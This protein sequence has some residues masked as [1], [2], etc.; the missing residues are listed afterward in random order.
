MAVYRAGMWLYASN[1]VAQLGGYLFWFVAAAT[2]KADVLG[3]VAYLVAVASILAFVLGLGVP[4]A[5]AR[6]YPATRDSTYVSGSLALSLIGAAAAALTALWR[7]SLALLTVVGTLSTYYGAYFQSRLDTFPIF[8]ATLAGQAARVALVPLLAHYGPDALATTY[9]IPGAILTVLGAAASRASP[10]L[11]KI[12]ELVKA[13][14]AVWL[15]G[16][17]SVLGTN[18]G[19][20]AAYNLANPET[21]GYVYIA[22]VLAN[23]AVGPATIITGVLLPYLSSTERREA[24]AENA[25]RLSLVVSL[26][27]AAVL[28]FGGRHFLELLGAHYVQA[29]PALVIYTVA[30]IL[31]LPASVLSSLTYAQGAYTT[32]LAGGLATNVTR[33]I[34]YLLYGASA[35][36]AAASF[37]AG[38]IVALAYYAAMQRRVAMSISRISPKIAVTAVPAAM[39][40][41]GIAPA[42]AGAVLSYAAALKLRIVTRAEVAEMARQVLPD[43]IYAKAAPLASKLLDILD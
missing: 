15:P 29:Y 41:L 33:I 20:V 37:L 8:I 31:S 39:A 10:S 23:A 11:T 27:L 34:L 38:T 22:Q 17:V 9:A 2:V 16:V 24:G 13:G 42:V 14:A 25:A 40:A 7:P 1:L 19:V 30:N 5:L 35:E 18:L 36:G 26:P 3:D 4:T 32:S 43:P 28:I 6:L 21:A 12:R